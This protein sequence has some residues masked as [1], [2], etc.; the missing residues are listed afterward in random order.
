VSFKIA[1]SDRCHS[2]PIV[3]SNVTTCNRPLYSNAGCTAEYSDIHYQ[4]LYV[5]GVAAS[6]TLQFGLSAG[7]SRLGFTLGFLASGGPLGGVIGAVGGAIVGA[8]F[9][10]YANRSIHCMVLRMQARRDMQFYNSVG[11]M[12]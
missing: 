8:I 12:A 6:L 7:F 3:V 9:A 2:H 10:F 5:A 11:G 1:N 4:D